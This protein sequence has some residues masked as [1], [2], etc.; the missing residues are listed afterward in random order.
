MFFYR[1]RRYRWFAALVSVLLAVVIL[2][3]AI[4]SL[5]RADSIYIIPDVV[6]NVYSYAMTVNNGNPVV[7][8]YSNNT[9][10]IVVA[11]CGNPSCQTDLTV[12]RP[13][14]SIVPRGIA[15]TIVNGNPFIAYS[16]IEGPDPFTAHLRVVDC[17]DPL[18]SQPPIMTTV[19]EGAFFAVAIENMCSW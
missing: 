1:M 9:N 13:I 7:S 16:T 10:N 12:I 4:S 19:D 8:Y 17:V 2:L 3:S 18:C 15:V 5:V 14:E 6:N 11:I